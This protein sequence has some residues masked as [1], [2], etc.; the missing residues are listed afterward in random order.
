MAGEDEGRHGAR[1]AAH[2]YRMAPHPAVTQGLQLGDPVP[3]DNEAEDL[4]PRRGVAS[5]TPRCP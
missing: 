2:G 1:G 4:R 5:H 3:W